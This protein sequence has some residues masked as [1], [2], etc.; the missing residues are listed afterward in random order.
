[1]AY[2]RQTV[3]KT[4]YKISKRKRNANRAKRKGSKKA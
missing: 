3:R 4:S 1:M 2:A